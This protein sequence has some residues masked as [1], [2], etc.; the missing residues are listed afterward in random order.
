MLHKQSR[1]DICQQNMDRYDKQADAFLRQ[2]HH[3]WWNMGPPL[4]A[5]VQTADYEME[6]F[7]IAQQEKV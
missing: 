2:N 1:S 7:T 6:T 3:P 4:R 5:G